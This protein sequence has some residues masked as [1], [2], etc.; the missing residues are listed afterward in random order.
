[1]NNSQSK[2]KTNI[3]LENYQGKTVSRRREFYENGTLYREGL[4]TKGHGGWAWDIP[5]GPI[6]TYYQ[7][8][9]IMSEEVFDEY[10][11]REGES[12]YYDKN[13]NITKRIT[14]R[15]DKVINEVIVDTAVEPNA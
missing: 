7:T 3:Q 13:G 15:K 11:N 4:Y 8:G 2:F 14:Y 9:I 12:I 10:G 5:M 1:M 6:K